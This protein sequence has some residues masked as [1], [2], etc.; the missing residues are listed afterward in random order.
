MKLKELKELL[1]ELWMEESAENRARIFGKINIKTEG[2]LD[3]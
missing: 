2:L 1:H 3:S